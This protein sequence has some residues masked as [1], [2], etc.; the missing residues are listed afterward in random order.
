MQFYIQGDA[1]GGVLSNKS[2]KNIDTTVFILDI[3][4]RGYVHTHT[5]THD[6]IPLLKDSFRT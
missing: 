5:H 6:I 2:I 4:L 3:A 1:L